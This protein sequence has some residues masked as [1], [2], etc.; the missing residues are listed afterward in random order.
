MTFDFNSIANSI[1]ETAPDASVAKT[2]GGGGEYT[3]PPVGLA[4]LRFVGYV[5]VGTRVKK[6]MGKPD[7]LQPTVHLIFELHGK[8]YEPKVLE[9]GTKIPVR[10]TVKVNHSLHEKAIYFKL[11]QR[12][13]YEG[14]AKHFSQLLGQA[15]L[16]NVNH[17]KFKDDKGKDV[18]IANFRGPDGLTIRPPRIEQMDEESGEVV[19]K[20]VPV[21]EAI[22]P[23]RLFVWNAAPTQIKPM[24]D[25]LYITGDEGK[26]DDKDHRTRNVLQAEVKRG[27]NFQG[28]PIAEYLSTASDGA[29]VYAQQA[30]NKT[31]AA[32]AAS[33]ADE[34]SDDIPF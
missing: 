26:E 3:P 32:A 19:N 12:M 16:G 14:K 33:D 11:F 24:W 28:S 4:R 20:L 13:N 25:S 1:A 34:F 2:G 21:P 9:D 30:T 29:I 27:L 23:I 22:S 17:F 8:G 18:V 31:K 7:A 15:Y 10:I 6:V 5:E